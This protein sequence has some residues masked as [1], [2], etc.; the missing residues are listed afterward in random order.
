MLPCVLLEVKRPVI[1]LIQLPQ[2]CGASNNQ[3]RKKVYSTVKNWEFT[4]HNLHADCSGVTLTLQALGEV[5][6]MPHIPDASSRVLHW[7]SMSKHLGK[8][9][10]GDSYCILATLTPHTC[11]WDTLKTMGVELG[12]LIVHV[13]LNFEHLHTAQNEGALCQVT[14]HPACS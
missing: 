9:V 5:V 2:I 4:W 10:R 6:L 1:S 14:Y 3:Q 11:S 12:V 8:G 13:Q 7:H